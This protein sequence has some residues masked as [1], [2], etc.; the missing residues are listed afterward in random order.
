MSDVV[1]VGSV[2]IDLTSHLPRWPEVGETVTAL[3]TDVGLGGKGANQAVAAARLGAGVS[4]IGAVGA[5]AFGQQ[6]VRMLGED[7]LQLAIETQ[8]QAATGM[9][10]IDVG[11]EGDNM[12][13]LAPGANATL[14]P[15]IILRHAPLI[16][17]AKVLL[18]QN[19]IPLAASL[20]A[21]RIARQHGATVVMDPAPAPQPIWDAETLAAFD[22]LTP[23]AHEAALI[24]GSA[25]SGLQ[26][27]EM[28]ATALTTLGP[29]G[30][31][32]TMGA[33]GVAW[34]IGEAVGHRPARK[35]ATVDTV[36]A[37]DCFNGALAVFLSQGCAAEQ[38]IDLAADAAALATTRPGA[39]AAAPRLSEVLEFREAQTTPTLTPH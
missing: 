13:R 26:A 21:A 7:N 15:E 11:P 12:I 16:A 30:A 2:N 10:F 29:R 8:A 27:A 39:A 28:T 14:T 31:I 5:D 37:G 34:Q 17:K 36:S 35:V 32:V 9:A 24:A 6:A 18:L 23:N 4:L 22:I 38:A 1:V 33:A 19:E 20:R 25:P 3:R